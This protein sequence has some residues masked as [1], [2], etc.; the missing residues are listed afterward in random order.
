MRESADLPVLARNADIAR[1]IDNSVFVIRADVAGRSEE[2]LSYGSSGIVDPD[3]MVLQSAQ[4]LSEDLII[5]DIGTSPRHGWDA[6]S[7]AAVMDE[8]G[9]LVAQSRATALETNRQ[10]G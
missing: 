5:A 4:T 10:S 6:A 2:L 8:Y 3:G 9:R 1:A 7:N